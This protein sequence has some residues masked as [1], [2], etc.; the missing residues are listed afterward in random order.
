MKGRLCNKIKRITG[1]V[2][3]K[4]ANLVLILAFMSFLLIGLQSP[5]W[6]GPEKPLNFAYLVADQLHEPA[7]MIMKEKKF[8]EDEGFKVTWGEYLAGA[9]VMQHMAAGEI[10]AATCGAV[11]T[12]ITQGRGVDVV[13]IAGS[14]QEGSRVVVADHIKKVE[15]LNGKKLGTP[16]IGSIQDS[17]IDMVERKYKIKIKHVHMKV[18]DMPIYL[19]KG[20]ID[21]FIAWEPHCSRSVDMGYGHFLLDSHDI[22]PGHQ[23]CVLVVQGKLIRNEPGTVR[24]IMR[25]YMR[26]MGYLIT[27]PEESKELMVKYTQLSTKVVDMALPTV[28]HVYPPHVNVPSLKVMAEGLIKGGKIEKTRVPDIDKFVAKSYDHSFINEYLANPCK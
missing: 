9:Y 12:M 11:P 26:G 3:M 4:K 2:K 5:S 18:T 8:L 6:G 10:D 15:D 24:K 25:A 23:C 19:K 17:M 20:E 21:G 28:K 22:L 7:P 14:N 1:G 16:G 27:H 13:M